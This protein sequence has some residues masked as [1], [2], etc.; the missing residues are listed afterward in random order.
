MRC[1]V[2]LS[3][4]CNYHELCYCL[5]RVQ[6]TVVA[7]KVGGKL[8]KAAKKTFKKVSSGNIVISKCP[9][10]DIAAAKAPHGKDNDSPGRNKGRHCQKFV[11][12]SLFHVLTR[13]HYALGLEGLDGCQQGCQEMEAYM[14]LNA[15]DNVRVHRGLVRLLDHSCPS[16][17][18][19]YLVLEWMPG[20]LAHFAKNAWQGGQKMGKKVLRRVMT[21]VFWCFTSTLVS[22]LALGEL[23]SPNLSRVQ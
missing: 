9:S 17:I 8:I 6:V 20:T 5:T 23:I 11:L 16:D 18:D 19:Q 1:N 13:L 7:V 12:S 21:R 22:L 14:S 10:R 2:F 4:T 15:L 3:Y